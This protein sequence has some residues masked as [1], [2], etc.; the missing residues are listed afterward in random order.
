MI[1]CHLMIGVRMAKDDAAHLFGSVPAPAEELKARVHAAV[2]AGFGD[3]APSTMRIPKE[4]YSDPRIFQEELR[5]SLSAPV[6]V[7]LGSTIPHA[8]DYATHDFLGNPVIVVR[9]DDG[10]ARVLLNACRHR[11]ATVVQD[12]GCARRFSCPYHGWTYDTEGSLVGVP[13]RRKGFVDLDV[14]THGLVEFPSEERHGFIWAVRN[15][16][17]LIDLDA[18]LGPFDAE[19]AAWPD[20]HEAA[21]LDLEIQANWKSCVEA[22]QETY[23]FPYVHTNSLPNNGTVPNIVTFDQ[24]GRHHRLGIPHATIGHEPEPAD[25]EQVVVIYYIYPN[26]VIAT[27]P[28]GG[29]MFQFSPGP[30]PSTTKIRHTVASR[31][32]VEGDVALFFEG[33]IP[34]MQAVIRDE[35]AIVLG[36]AGAGLGA[37]H[38]DVVLGR[39]EVGVQGVHRQL[40]SDVPDTFAA[41]HATQLQSAAL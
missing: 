41:G 18:H 1:T 26:T 35:D 14:T 23:H 24:I 21:V 19:L 15:P 6:V 22:F 36:R 27:S 9:G 20:Y 33:Y 28:L 10:R 38:T 8:G 4:R 34:L 40:M 37:G 17:G 39:N 16:D 13:D 2:L 25:G 29:E 11:G 12:A 5:T 31:W 3:L 7:T 30:N 32:P